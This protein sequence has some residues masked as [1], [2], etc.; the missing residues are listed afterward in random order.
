MT[1]DISGR[2]LRLPFYNNLTA[3]RPTGRERL[4]Q[5][6]GR[7][8]GDPRLGC[9]PCGPRSSARRL[10]DH[11]EYWWYRARASLLQCTLERFL[12]DPEVVLDV[13]SADGPSVGWMRGAHAR[14]TMDINPQG[15]KPGEGVCASALALPFADETFDVVERL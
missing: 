15:L 2:L 1:D 10:C 3:P 7:S 11:P 5:I 12:G 8:T 4:H 14:I 6:T 13:G 9:V